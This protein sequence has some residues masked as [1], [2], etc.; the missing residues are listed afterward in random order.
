M[1]SFDVAVLGV[2]RATTGLRCGLLFHAGQRRPLR[3]GWLAPVLRPVAVHPERVLVD[4]AAVRR[5]R[6]GGYELNVWTVDGA[7]EVRRMVG[8]G[9]DG[10]I[11]NDPGAARGVVAGA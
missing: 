10:I 2:V 8:L 4:E 7:E 3:E 9:V 6:E 1:S 11:C 5:W